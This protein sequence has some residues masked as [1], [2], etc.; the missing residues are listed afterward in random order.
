MRLS[1]STLG[2]PAWP[3]PRIVTAAVEFGYQG[4]ELRGLQ[5]HIDLREAPELRPQRIAG[6]RRLIEDAGLT[7]CSLDSSASFAD[8][9]NLNS[10]LAEARGYIALAHDLGCPFVRVFGGD[11]PSNSTLEDGAANI[12]EALCALADVACPAGVRLLLETHD[13]FSTGAGVA[14]ALAH[15][16]TECAGALWDLHHP[17]R[18]GEAPVDTYRVLADRLCHTHVKDSRAGTYCLAGQGDVPLAHMVKLL[19]QHPRAD[20]LWLS[21]EW[22]KRWIPTLAEPEIVFPQYARALRAYIGAVT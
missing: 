8:P 10:A 3:L 14:M 16:P 19:R 17:Y 2:C 12:A 13:A 6:T 20:K 4:L 9:A 22:E 21:L 7:V 15:A 5:E 11:P 18:H 1:F